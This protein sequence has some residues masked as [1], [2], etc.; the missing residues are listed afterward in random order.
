LGNRSCCLKVFVHHEKI[1]WSL[2]RIFLIIAW[3]FLVIQSM[4][5]ISIISPP[6][7][8]SLFASKKT[9]SSFEKHFGR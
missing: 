9:Q 8:N 2:L 3:K 1:F 6:K 7:K 5:V 4:V